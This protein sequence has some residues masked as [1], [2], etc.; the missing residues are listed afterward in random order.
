MATKKMSYIEPAGYFPES[1]RKKYF[2][3]GYSATG[4]KKSSGSKTKAGA[5]KSTAKK[6]K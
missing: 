6:A 3:D 2:P 1:L 4:A 5:K